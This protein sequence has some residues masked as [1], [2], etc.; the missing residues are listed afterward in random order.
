MRVAATTEPSAPFEPPPPPPEPPSPPVPPPPVPPP[1]G[2]GPPT[3]IEAKLP[4]EP[5]LEQPAR[6]PAVASVAK[7]KP[8]RM[9]G[10]PLDVAGTVQSGLRRCRIPV[11]GETIRRV[12]AGRPTMAFSPHRFQ[13]CRWLDLQPRVPG[14]T[15]H[16]NP[17]K[18]C[19]F[20]QRL[21]WRQSI[22]RPLPRRRQPT[23]PIRV[24]TRVASARDETPSLR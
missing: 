7:I 13:G 21:A 2:P 22:G 5:E 17:D 14:L 20:S 15:T 4:D 23:S 16:S 8:T 12:S 6:M 11:T 1:S 24:A 18:I 19:K 10:S 9:S 3:S